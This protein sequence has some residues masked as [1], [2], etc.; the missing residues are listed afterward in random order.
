MKAAQEWMS[1]VPASRR[2]GMS[3]RELYAAIDE[4]RID[5]R[6][7]GRRLAIEVAIDDGTVDRLQEEPHLRRAEGLDGGEGPGGDLDE[8]PRSVTAVLLVEARHRASLT[9]VELAR[10]AQVPWPT[11][12]AYEQGRRQPKVATL[13]RLLAA[14]GF[15]VRLRLVPPTT[16]P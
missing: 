5:A 8:Q 11:I 16:T 10:R 14:A 12:S 7:A 4:G 9:Q 6:W 13:L 15:E 3:V 1:T 2:L